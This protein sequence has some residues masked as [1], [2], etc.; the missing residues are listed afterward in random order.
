MKLNDY[1][2]ANG[3]E[4]AEFAKMIGVRVQS[5]YRY[6]DGKQIPSKDIMPRIFQ[7]TDGQVTANSFYELTTESR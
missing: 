5:V 6:K 7:A 1:L 3:L 4:P 2:T